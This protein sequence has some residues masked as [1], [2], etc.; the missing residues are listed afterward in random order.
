MDDIITNKSHI[1]FNKKIDVKPAAP[2]GT[3]TKPVM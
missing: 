1:I 2:K 3:I